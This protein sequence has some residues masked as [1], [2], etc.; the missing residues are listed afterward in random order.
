MVNLMAFQKSKAKS[1]EEKA[2]VWS[3][4]TGTYKLGYSQYL[5][6]QSNK[7]KFLILIFLVAVFVLLVIAAIYGYTLVQ[8]IDQL[9]MFSKMIKPTLALL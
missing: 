7:L 2:M 6:M 5:A 3:D 1:N 8:R 4:P 9:D